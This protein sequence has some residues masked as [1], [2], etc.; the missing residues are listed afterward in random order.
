PNDTDLDGDNLPDQQ[1]SIGTAAAAP[2]VAR[3]SNAAADSSD[4]TYAATREQSQLSAVAKSPQLLAAALDQSLLIAS[5][6][7]ADSSSA[8]S[9]ANSIEAAA[10]PAD[11][12]RLALV[13]IDQSLLGETNIAPH[14]ARHAAPDAADEAALDELFAL[15]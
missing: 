4:G 10:A 9:A 7:L 6:S 2:S 12:Q 1:F 3:S 8:T 14:H 11:P 15:I 5:T 13:V